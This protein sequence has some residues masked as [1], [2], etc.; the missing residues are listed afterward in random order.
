MVLCALA[1][2]SS[3]KSLNASWCLVHRN[4]KTL[5]IFLQWNHYGVFFSF[6]LC[7][8]VL[9]LYLY[10]D[11]CCCMTFHKLHWKWLSSNTGWNQLPCYV[12]TCTVTQDMQDTCRLFYHAKLQA[13][14]KKKKRLLVFSPAHSKTQQ[15][16]GKGKCVA[17]MFFFFRE[18]K[19]FLQMENGKKVQLLRKKSLGWWGEW[20]QQTCFNLMSISVKCPRAG[21]NLTLNSCHHNGR[22]LDHQEPIRIHHC[23]VRGLVAITLISKIIT[24]ITKQ[25][26]CSVVQ[27][28]CRHLTHQRKTMFG[29]LDVV[30]FTLR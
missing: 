13:L 21:H 20:C 12:L 19:S 30:S 2:Q 7:K 25:K 26:A 17:A 16:E 10:W 15:T 5:E 11:V 14:K 18:T 3:N 29:M 28:G 9:L 22:G 1:D 27:S 8:C 4:L 24:C 23:A 6:G